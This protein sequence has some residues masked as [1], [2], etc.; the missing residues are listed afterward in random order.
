MFRSEFF[1]DFKLTLTLMA[2]CLVAHVGTAMSAEEQRPTPGKSTVSFQFRTPF[3]PSL[4]YAP[5]FV[6]Q[7]LY[8]PKLNLEGKALQGKGS[9]AAVQ[10]VAAGS[11]QMGYSAVT[12]IAAG[13]QQGL[14]I[15]VI[16]V[17]QRRDPT[18]L[19]FLKESGI[20]E[21]KDVIG[22]RVGSFPGG[23]TTPLFRAMLR[24]AGIDEKTVQI[25]NVPP[26]GTIPVLLEKRVD[27][28][29]EFAGGGD[30]R[31][32]CMGYKMDNIPSA[33]LGL[34]IYGQAVFVNTK[35]AEQV[36]DNVVARALLGFI[37]GSMLVKS[38]PERAIQIINSLFPES[39]RDRIQ[40]WAKVGIALPA[41]QSP[42][43]RVLREKGFGWVDEGEMDRTQK[44]LLDSGLIDKVIDPRSYYTNK[45]LEQP[46]LRQA[47]ME[48]LRTPWSD[49]PAE[50]KKQCGL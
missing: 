39:P 31:M 22:K 37:R 24:R 27:A 44:V 6:A 45:Y 1:F 18:A 42:D 41:E 40:E 5:A 23:A 34:D 46:E 26:G 12:S 49:L 20:R 21:I 7:E 33:S 14:P 35:W 48:W 50:I 16:A 25:V 32:G 9:A 3:A 47:A 8:W 13:I 43:S 15:K 38:N 28:V 17:V 29:A 30:L 10:T 2:L 19:I 36:G 4:G 11:E